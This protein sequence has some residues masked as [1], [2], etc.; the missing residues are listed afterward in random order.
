VKASFGL[1]ET[2]AWSEKSGKVSP[3]VSMGMG[4]SVGSSWDFLCGATKVDAAVQ[5]GDSKPGS[6][7]QIDCSDNYDSLS[8]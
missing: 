8:L 5:Q 2:T 7:N 1:V 3:M 4:S 6:D